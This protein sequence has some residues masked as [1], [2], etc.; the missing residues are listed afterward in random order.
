MLFRSEFQN[1]TFKN[2]REVPFVFSEA[3]KKKSKRFVDHWCVTDE[4]RKYWYVRALA[5]FMA[6]QQGFQCSKSDNSNIHIEIADQLNGI[7]PGASIWSSTEQA[8]EERVSKAVDTTVIVV[9][10]PIGSGKSTIANVI[11]GAGSEFV[12]IDG[13]DLGLGSETCLKLGAERNS[14]SLWKI[15]ESIMGGKIPV[16][17]T[18]GG[19]LSSFRGNNLV[20]R[21]VLKEM[22]GISVRLIMCSVDPSLTNSVKRVEGVNNPATISHYEDTSVVTDVVE[23]RLK[24]GVWKLDPKFSKGGKGANGAKGVKGFSK[25][26]AARS[27][28]NAK[29]A[30]MLFQE[31]DISFVFPV[32]TPENYKS[33]YEIDI[34][35]VLDECKLPNASK[36][37]AHFQQYRV[38]CEVSPPVSDT[39]NTRILHVTL[40][41]DERRGIHEDLESISKLYQT[42]PKGNH[43]STFWNLCKG[44]N[45]CKVVIP[46]HK[47]HADNST[48][49]TFDSGNHQAKDMKIVASAIHN[50]ESTV[51]LKTQ[52]GDDTIVYD[53]PKK[54]IP[55]TIRFLSVFG[56]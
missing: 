18:G 19:I 55:C 13:D 10:G 25:M 49:I 42:L 1:T 27:R 31:S 41:F 54:G 35:E 45:N 12:E 7:N 52:K 11:A 6:Y 29:F 16:I 30:E 32:V 9:V 5:G 14:Y 50:S 53:I 46:K 44:K 3:L 15:A 51:T 43:Q 22:L 20:L 2:G 28:K 24:S 36:M 23:R 33:M 38:L 48:H 4:G 56:I 40:G 39:A 8:F 17:S 47:L 34:S 37:S 21:N 26:I